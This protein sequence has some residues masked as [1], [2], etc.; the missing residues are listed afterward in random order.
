MKT[1]LHNGLFKFKLLPCL[2]TM[3][4]ILGEISAQQLAFPEAEGYG[5]FTTGG[6]GGGVIEVTNLDDS[7]PGSLRE[8]INTLGTRTIVFRVSGTIELESDLKIRH[9]NVTIAGQTAPGDGICIRN[10]PVVLDAHNVIVRYIRFRLGDI[11][12]QDDDSFW[13]RNRRDV[14]IDHCSMSWAIDECSSF[15][16]NQDFT[17]QWC[18]I[19][20]SLYHSVHPKGNHGYG[21]IWGG[22]GATFHHNLLAHHT[23]RNPRFNG[24]R[25]LE[26]PD[27]EIVDFVNNVIYN[28]GFNSAYGGEA[29]NQNLRLNYYKYG[30]ATNG[31]VKYRIVNPSDTAGNWYVNGNYVYGNPEITTDNWNGGV[32]GVYAA[33]QKDKRALSPFPIAE[34]DTQSAEEAYELVLQHAG[35]NF[36]VQDSVD[37]R[38]IYE[39]QTGTAQYGSTWNGGGNGIIDSQSDVGGWPILHSLPPPVDSDQDGMPDEWELQKG[40]NP[41]D[42]TDRNIINSYGYTKLEEYLNGL[43]NNATTVRDPNISPDE[44]I[45]SANFPNPFN[46]ST[47]V[48]FYLPKPGNVDIAI[49]DLNGQIVKT[50]FSGYNGAGDQRIRWDGTND[51]FIPVSSG[52]YICSIKYGNKF[53]SIKML[54]LK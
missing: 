43:L 17:M 24:S 37:K 13:G 44:F 50:L 23:S 40:L 54:L 39:V 19:S 42:S 35:A 46:P 27:K 51:Q 53:K 49:Y 31:G 16:D 3:I 45:V 30:P 10:Y 34:V 21:G 14:I 5:R 1:L 28:W 38:V 33:Y 36:P 29:G 6:R 22:W 4:F 11:A 8:A 12:Q 25:Y 32:Q 7:G 47:I 9:A 20:E 2:I 52:M 26:Q 15:Y 41:E 48:A 18:I